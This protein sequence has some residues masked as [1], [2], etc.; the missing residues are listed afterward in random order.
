MTD[1][2]PPPLPTAP[3]RTVP[4]VGLTLLLWIGLWLLM[5]WFDDWAW[6]R[7][8]WWDFG[9]PT[10]GTRKLFGAL[11]PASFRWQSVFLAPLLHGSLIGLFFLVF[12]WRGVGRLLVSL[13]GPSWTWVAFVGGGAAAAYGHMQAHPHGAIP[14]AVGPFDPILCGVGVQL[15]WGILVPGQR[16]LAGRAVKTLLFLALFMLV[17]VWWNDAVDF[18]QLASERFREAIGA[19]GMLATFVLGLALAVVILVG[20]RLAPTATTWLG[21]GLALAALGGVLY[22]GATQAVPILERGERAQAR[23][24]LSQLQR[25][26]ARVK[27]LVKQDRATEEKR[28][29]LAVAH[30]RLV[31]HAYLE[32]LDGREAL[33]AYAE[34]L[35]VY[36]RPVD[37]PFLTEPQLK[38]RFRAWYDGHEKALRERFALPERP[39]DP[40]QGL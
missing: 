23:D 1:V 35:G 12:F 2:A 22:A 11:V 25:T 39:F 38:Q 37:A 15:G 4:V 34:I 21:R 8:A 40:W 30:G 26:E 5:M 3:R 27:D 6:H 18:E 7:G 36:M 24:F 14:Y 19:E 10:W 28:N 9:S 16:A 13:L 20:R 33:L 31:N 32:D 17:I 29:A